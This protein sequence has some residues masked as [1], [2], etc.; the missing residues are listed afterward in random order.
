M[1]ALSFESCFYYKWFLI[2]QLPVVDDI[3]RLCREQLKT[4]VWTRTVQQPTLSQVIQHINDQYW[5]HDGVVFETKKSKTKLN[6]M[7]YNGCEV[8]HPLSSVSF[9]YSLSFHVVYLYIVFDSLTTFK[10]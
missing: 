2:Q 4:S 7:M 6:P 10:N 5:V 3:Q 1:D 9:H 8:I